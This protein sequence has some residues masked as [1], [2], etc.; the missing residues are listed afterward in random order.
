MKT[1]RVNRYYCDFCKKSGCSAPHL[2]KHEEHCTMNP[3]RICGLC[4][5]EN[6]TSPEELAEAVASI[7]NVEQFKHSNSDEFGESEWYS[8]PEE[9]VK[10]VLADLSDRFDG[11]PVCTFTALR[12]AGWAGII[13]G[14]F[15]LK[16]RIAAWWSD[17]NNEEDRRSYG[18]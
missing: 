16:E 15:N 2:R 3:R 18:Y 17:V 6:N 10:T 12:Q 13:H 1:K 9:T 11:C 5:V 4:A 14:Q 8:I 7:P